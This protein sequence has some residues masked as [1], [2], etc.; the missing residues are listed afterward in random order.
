MIFFLRI[1]RPPRSTRTDTLFPYT[2][3]FR[4]KS[5]AAVDFNA[6]QITIVIFIAVFAALS[7]II[8]DRGPARRYYRRRGWPKRWPDEG[9][10]KLLTLRADAPSMADPPVQLTPVIV[11]SFTKRRILQQP[12]ARVFFAV[13]K[14]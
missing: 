12:A 6:D 7:G 2:T 1:R 10:G 4:S 13:D 5:I 3:L 11:S 14:L 8:F 9:R